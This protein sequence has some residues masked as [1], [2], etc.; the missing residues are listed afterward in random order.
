MS[1]IP[2]EVKHADLVKACGPL[3]DLLGITEHDIYTRPGLTVTAEEVT[4]LM[5]AGPELK[6]G[7]RKLVTPEQ[8]GL[9]SPRGDTDELAV[10][11][12]IKTDLHPDSTVQV[13]VRNAERDAS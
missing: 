6:S 12:R 2:K 8:V 1:N 5:C 11:V 4:F 13:A 3:F 7:R 10:F 9:T